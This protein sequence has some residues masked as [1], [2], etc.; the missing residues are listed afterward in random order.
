MPSSCDWLY[1]AVDAVGGAR[2]YESDGVGVACCLGHGLVL[3]IQADAHMRTDT[4]L[5]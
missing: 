2:L 3:V 5:P 4:Y 1:Y